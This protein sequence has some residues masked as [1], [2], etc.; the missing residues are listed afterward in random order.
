MSIATEITRLQG[1]K[2][3]IRTALVTQGIAQASSH[4]MADFSADILAIQ[5]GSEGVY[6]TVT[7]EDIY[8]NVSNPVTIY[9]KDSNGNILDKKQCPSS[10]IVNFFVSADN[11]TLPATFTISNSLNDITT[12][13]EANMYG[14]YNVDMNKVIVALI[15]K[16]TSNTTWSTLEEGQV[17]GV[18]SAYN[19]YN[20]DYD[21]Y[22]AF[23]NDSYGWVP[24]SAE[25]GKIYVQYKFVKQV[26]VLS[27]K[28]KGILSSTN[29]TNMNFTLL[30]SNTGEENDF[31][32]IKEIILAKLGTEYE[33]NIPKANYQY[34]RLVANS[35]SSVP[36]GGEIRNCNGYKIQ[37]YGY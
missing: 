31:T 27:I 36:S 35:V 26:T 32:P 16:M 21:A 10:L 25:Y 33:F 28:M 29:L 19:I 23:N 18:A 12:S 37:L 14:W 30:G 11:V 34:F 7:C 2:T 15:P 5:G 9:L 24:G 20:N 6:I 17:G 1:I 4:N 3:D 22:K 13:F 8:Y